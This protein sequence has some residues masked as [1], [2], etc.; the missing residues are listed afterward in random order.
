[1]QGPHADDFK[2]QCQ[3]ILEQLSAV[4]RGEPVRSLPSQ[5]ASRLLLLNNVGSDVGEHA[6]F[7]G[8]VN[9]LGDAADEIGI[10]L[11]VDQVSLNGL[12]LDPRNVQQINEDYDLAILGGGNLLDDRSVQT[13][14]GWGFDIP[15]SLLPTLTVPLA[16]YAVG[17]EQVR[18][19]LKLAQRTIRHLKKT[20]ESAAH[21]SVREPG[22]RQL[23]SDQLRVPSESM[24]LVPDPGLSV[25]PASVSLP[26]VNRRTIAVSLHQADQRHP[27]Q[28]R[29]ER[30]LAALGQALRE[31]VEQDRV[32]VLLVPH[33]VSPASLNAA[34]ALARALPEGSFQSLVELAPKLYQHP[35]PRNAGVFCGIYQRVGAVIGQ[36]FHSLVL[37]FGVGTP[38]LSLASSDANRWA[39]EWYGMPSEMHIDTHEFEPDG[40]ATEITD[41]VRQLLAQRALLQQCSFL[42][43]AELQQLAVGQIRKLFSSTLRRQPATPPLEATAPAAAVST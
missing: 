24:G 36:P 38:T 25:G 22:S 27:V 5:R 16:V 13:V 1:V 32:N 14:S 23:L 10:E 20:L 17:F 9:L 28:D 15:D 42:R 33:Q 21:F 12:R 19:D 41:R 35:D 18:S 43:R 34:K 4:E 39:H 6:L 11:D 2:Q 8:L 30:L 3:E 40:L 37:P 31:L 26:G 29:F 7:S